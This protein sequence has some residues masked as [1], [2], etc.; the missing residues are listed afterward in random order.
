MIYFFIFR[1]GCNAGHL[2]SF[3]PLDNGDA[4]NN[5]SRLMKVNLKWKY[6]RNSPEYLR[7][8]LS[9]SIYTK[10]PLLPNS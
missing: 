9:L 10:I 2:E 3:I 4:D 7:F 5:I 8:P 1:S 6:E